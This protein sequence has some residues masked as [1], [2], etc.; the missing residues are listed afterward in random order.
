MTRTLWITV[1][2]WLL[3]GSLGLV[4]QEPRESSLTPQILHFIEDLQ[5]ETGP[6]RTWAARQ[7]VLIG[8]RAVPEL[9][10]QYPQQTYVVRREIVTILGEIGSAAAQSY[11]MA[12]AL[13]D[14]DQGVRSRTALA[15]LNLSDRVPVILEKIKQIRHPNAEIQR[16]IEA[17]SETILYRKIE[18][19]LISL[20][21]PQGGFGF[22]VGQFEPLLKY[23]EAAVMPLLEMF[24]DNYA[25]VNIA[26]GQTTEIAY[27]IRVLAGEAL[28][29]FAPYLGKRKSAVLVRLSN[30]QNHRQKEIQEIATYTLY[31]LGD[32][33]RLN[34]KIEALKSRIDED[35]MRIEQYRRMGHND[36]AASLQDQVAQNCFELAMIYLRIRKDLEAIGILKQAIANDPYFAIAYYN[37]A[38]AYSS[39]GEIEAGMDALE[40]AVAL[41]YED[42]GWIQKDGDLGNLKKSPRFQKLVEELARRLERP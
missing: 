12:E 14:E 30:L 5:Q 6:E 29:D 25:F 41:G 8:E 32:Q 28:A 1:S 20:V 26:Y 36:Y 15:L 4:A 7:L 3:V 11:L 42:L 17:L 13:V 27:K 9:T 24:E 33:W 31:M 16:D 34:Q 39:L 2:L 37:M 10:A 21:S 18:N 40:K 35:T 19:E 22:F 38:C 23:G